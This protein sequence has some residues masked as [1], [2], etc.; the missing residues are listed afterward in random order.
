MRLDFQGKGRL[1]LAKIRTEGGRDA[2]RVARALKGAREHNGFHF[3][4]SQ[5]VSRARARR[6]CAP[7]RPMH[8][9][10][11]LV[12]GDRMCEWTGLVAK[13]DCRRRRRRRRG[14]DYCPRRRQRQRT[15]R[16]ESNRYARARARAYL[17]RVASTDYDKG[18][19]ASE[20][21]RVLSIIWRTSLAR[22]CASSNF[23]LCAARL[24]ST[25][26]G[27]EASLPWPLASDIAQALKDYML[28]CSVTCATC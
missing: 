9:H 23:R 10:P 8:L 13:S 12:A 19:F 24:D 21:A 1:S 22:H 6:S 2:L 17:C 14:I 5:P 3:D 15:L 27:R 4:M 16:C 26:L 25:Q 18:S 28:A 7:G 20:R 11:P